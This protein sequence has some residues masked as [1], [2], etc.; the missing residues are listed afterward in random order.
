MVLV[1]LSASWQHGIQYS[2]D[3]HGRQRGIQLRE[4]IPHLPGFHQFWLNRDTELSSPIR[5]V[6]LP[7]THWHSLACEYTPYIW[8]VFQIHTRSKPTTYGRS[9]ENI[10]LSWNISNHEEHSTAIISFL[11]KDAQILHWGEDVSYPCNLHPLALTLP[12]GIKIGHRPE[13]LYTPKESVD[14]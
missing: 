13:A 9:P 7:G 3:S 14:E 8:L 4:S 2:K 5:L 10:Q 1:S 6:H 12:L 11:A